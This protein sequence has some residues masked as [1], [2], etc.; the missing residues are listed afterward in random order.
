MKGIG[1]FV[2]S[3]CRRASRRER[4]RTISSAL[5]QRRRRRR[6]LRLLAASM[7]PRA[8][9]CRCPSSSQSGCPLSGWALWAGRL[10][11]LQVIRICDSTPETQ[12]EGISMISYTECW[13]RARAAVLP[14]L[15]WYFIYFHTKMSESV[16]C[17][18]R[19]HQ[20]ERVGGRLK[21]VVAHC[22]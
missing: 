3:A 2:D 7:G 13:T 19:T 20:S 15:H 12:A 4:K 8:S 18:W 6:P 5:R 17:G 14:G 9:G 11:C 22:C 10:A 1:H 16:S 21:Y